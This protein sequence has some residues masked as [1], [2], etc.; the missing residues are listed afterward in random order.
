MRNLI[1][2]LPMAPLRDEFGPKRRDMHPLI[3]PFP[4]HTI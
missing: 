3:V 1:S 4:L 2:G